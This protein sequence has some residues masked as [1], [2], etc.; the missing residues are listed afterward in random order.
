LVNDSEY[1]NSIGTQPIPCYCGIYFFLSLAL[2]LLRQLMRAAAR[3][4]TPTRPP[5]LGGRS[6]VTKKNMREKK[7]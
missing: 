6:E 2:L 4:P 5:F 1:N 7:E 3:P